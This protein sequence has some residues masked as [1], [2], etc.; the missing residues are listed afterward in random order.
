MVGTFAWRTPWS[1][2]G[3][4]DELL[5]ASSEAM[6]YIAHDLLD[7]PASRNTMTLLNCL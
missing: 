1:R 7:T 2:L 5:P 4:K 3:K 6:S